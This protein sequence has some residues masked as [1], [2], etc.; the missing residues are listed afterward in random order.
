MDGLKSVCAYDDGNAELST[1]EKL[2]Y[3]K[4]QSTIHH[5]FEEPMAGGVDL[6]ASP[7]VA[8]RRR[9]LAGKSG[10]AGLVHNRKIFAIAVF[11]SLGGLLY[12]YNQVSPSGMP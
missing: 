5:L 9:A 11:A 2:S 3:K 6:G 7:Y 4:S 8:E 10:W 1:L 12:G